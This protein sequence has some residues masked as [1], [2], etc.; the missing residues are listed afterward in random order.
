MKI[1][2]HNDKLLR[3]ERLKPTPQK[4]VLK[5]CKYCQK[6]FTLRRRKK[7]QKMGS[8]EMVDHMESEHATD[9]KD[10]QLHGK[11]YNCLFLNSKKKKCPFLTY[12][13]SAAIAHKVILIIM[14]S[15]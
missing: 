12:H 1:K 13:S 2:R 11:V 8:V 7:G 9:H 6:E 5:S 10:L 14:K 3:I 4:K 15:L